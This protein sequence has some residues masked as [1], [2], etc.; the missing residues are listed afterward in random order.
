MAH[1]TRPGVGY[2]NRIGPARPGSAARAI[3][4]TGRHSS[5][6]RSQPVRAWRRHVPALPPRL[7][8]P[9]NAFLADHLQLARWQQAARLVRPTGAPRVAAFEGYDPLRL[10]GLSGDSLSR[11]ASGFAMTVRV[12]LIHAQVRRL[13]LESGQWQSNVWGAPINQCH[14]AGTNLLFS[15][16]VLDGLTSLGYRFTPV[17]RQAL[18]HLWRYAGYLLGIENELLIAE[19]SDG[20]QLLDMISAFEPHPD[21]DSRALVHAL[22]LTSFGYVRSFRVGR[23]CRVTLCYGISRAL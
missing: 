4:A 14:L 19:E 8:G 21:D 17:E 10:R 12:R 2:G 23:M 22:M 18:I 15:V 3:S 13:L 1:A 5:L 7:R 16:G 11:F 20:H 6:G 9:R